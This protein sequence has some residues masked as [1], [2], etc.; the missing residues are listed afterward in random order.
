LIEDVGAVA[1]VDAVEGDDC[2]ISK[3]MA[4][5]NIAIALPHKYC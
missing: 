1:G 2:A 3:T 5:F 4:N